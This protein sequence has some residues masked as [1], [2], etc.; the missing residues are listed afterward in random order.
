MVNYQTSWRRQP[1]PRGD[2][3]YRWFESKRLR[4]RILVGWFPTNQFRLFRLALS[5]S[6]GVDSFSLQIAKF[7]IVAGRAFG[8]FGQG[9]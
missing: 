3:M 8:R 7:E 6:G 9:G 2:L 5:R 1:A 4:L